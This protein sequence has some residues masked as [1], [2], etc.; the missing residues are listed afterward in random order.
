L[1]NDIAIEEQIDLTPSHAAVAV[2]GV[3]PSALRPVACAHEAMLKG[4]NVAD[5]LDFSGAWIAKAGL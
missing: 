1:P 5:K 2:L 3:Y 4:E